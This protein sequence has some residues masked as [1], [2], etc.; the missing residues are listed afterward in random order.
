MIILTQNGSRI[1]LFCCTIF[2]SRVSKFKRLK[3][4][5]FLLNFKPQLVFSSFFLL[6]SKINAERKHEINF[7]RLRVQQQYTLTKFP[8]LF[9]LYCFLPPICSDNANTNRMC[10]NLYIDLFLNL[11]WLAFI[12]LL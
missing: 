7:H 2:A 12:I 1:N 9:V 11:L 4:S 10:L 8:H 6:T 3:N 5:D